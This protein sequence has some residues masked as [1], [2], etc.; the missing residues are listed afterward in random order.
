MRKSEPRIF[1]TLLIFMA[2][3]STGCQLS[4]EELD[5]E[6]GEIT[7][8][9]LMNPELEGISINIVELSRQGEDVLIV[10]EVINSTMHNVGHYRPTYLRFEYFDGEVWRVLRQQ[11]PF[12]VTSNL[13]VTSSFWT[14]ERTIYWDFPFLSGGLYR[15]RETFAILDLEIVFD[16]LIFHDVVAEFYWP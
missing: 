10:Y 8:T 7:E 2:F 6:L 11:S 9:L 1:T 4:N 12:I 5:R 15:I 14:S 13:P 3:I 16:E